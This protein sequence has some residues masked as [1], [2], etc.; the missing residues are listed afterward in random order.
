VTIPNWYEAVLLALAAWRVFHLLAFDDLLDR[1]RRY[2]TRLGLKWEED[3]DPVPANYRIRF[4]NF[5]TCSFCFGFWVAL[6]WWGAWQ[7]W[8]HGT[9]VAA[10]P[11]LLSALLIGAQELLHSE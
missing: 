9:L 4:A 8:P 1:P 10:T 11:F 5:L 6:A 2:V 3:G 7:V